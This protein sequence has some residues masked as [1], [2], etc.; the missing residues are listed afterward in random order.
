ML[1]PRQRVELRS[2]AHGEELILPVLREKTLPNFSLLWKLLKPGPKDS[3]RRNSFSPSSR[4]K[5]VSVK[6]KYLYH[7]YQD[8]DADVFS[9]EPFVVWFQSPFT[10]ETMT[11][12]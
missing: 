1:C 2:S 5:L 3:A 6:D 11:L 7:D 10:G 8:G 12:Y 4:E 9:R